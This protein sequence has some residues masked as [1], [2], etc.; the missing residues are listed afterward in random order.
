MSV[1]MSVYGQNPPFVPISDPPPFTEV[2]FSSAAWGDYDN[3]G[4]LD[5]LLT[6]TPDSTSGISEIYRN[7]GNDTFV[8]LSAG[9]TGVFRGA[10]AW[11]DYDNDNDLD[12]L[13][14]GTPDGATGISKIYRNDGGI[15]VEWSYGNFQNLS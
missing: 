11:G 8:P 1:H 12:I 3:D 15:F 14:T 2:R 6:G 5:V 13:L 10:V 4:D 9:L 7:D